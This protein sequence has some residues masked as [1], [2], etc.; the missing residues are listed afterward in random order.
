MRGA[1]EDGLLDGEGLDLRGQGD[2]SLGL[3]GAF[4]GAGGEGGQGQQESE[5][6]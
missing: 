6:G 3:P 5:C 1:G 4:V 2:E